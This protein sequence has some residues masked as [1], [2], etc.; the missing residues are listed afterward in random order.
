[1]LFVL[2][3]SSCSGKSAIAERCSSIDRLSVHDFDDV[4]V[5]SD[6]DLVWRQST[7]EGWIQRA[8]QEEQRGRDTLL[9]GQ[10][11]LGEILAAPSTPRLE[12]IAVALVDVD[13]HERW[14]RLEHRDPGKWDDDTKRSF[15]NWARWHRTHADDPQADPEA[16]INGS[17]SEM[18]WARWTSWNPDDPRWSTERIDTTGRS[19]V[20]ST[21]AVT[22]WITRTRNSLQDGRLPL[23]R[24]W[25][26]RF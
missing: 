7:L 14:I 25:D 2:T 11:P 26:R 8:L 17:N 24:G 22:E 10:S 12:G 19:T 9:T 3:G 18:A 16:I 15:V 4:G 13:D 5:P 20:E 21:A 1:V 23:A 6:A